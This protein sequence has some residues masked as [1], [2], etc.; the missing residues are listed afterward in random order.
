[1]G[2]IFDSVAGDSNKPAQKNAP[3]AGT[4]P[5]YTPGRPSGDIFD[6]VAAGAYDAQPSTDNVQQPQ[7]GLLDTANRFYQSNPN[8]S[9]LAKVG[10]SLGRLG[11]AV[12]N[13]VHTVVSPAKDLWKVRLRGRAGARV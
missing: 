3:A 4:P 11:M 10:K 8:D 9:A 1:M 2:D 13:L 7:P 6:H 5:Q 12:P